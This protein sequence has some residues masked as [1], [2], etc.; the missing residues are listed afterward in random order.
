MSNDEI[1]K[2]IG[3]AKIE[4]ERNSYPHNWGEKCV[5]DICERLLASGQFISAKELREKIVK[6]YQLDILL[7][8]TL[9]WLVRKQSQVASLDYT[10]IG[11][12]KIRIK[13]LFVSKLL[14]EM[15]IEK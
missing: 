7:E 11:D 13:R 6:D 1:Q 12:A 2:I 15:V 10:D 5:T 3:K 4:H 9:Q 14:D 8:S